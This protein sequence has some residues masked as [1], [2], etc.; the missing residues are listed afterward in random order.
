[1]AHPHPTVADM[2]DKRQAR[3]KI[4]IH[5]FYRLCIWLPIV[6]PAVLIVAARL[7]TLRLARGPVI[8]ELL[9]YSLLYG[10]IPY[11][12]VATVATGWVGTQTEERIRHVMYRAPLLMVAVFAPF[13]LFTGLA[14]GAL[15]PFVAVAV[16]GSIVIL[17]IGYGYVGLTMLLR[18]LFA[19]AIR[20]SAGA[21]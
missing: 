1:M 17:L 12:V 10:G 11:A 21:A 19:P 2:T 18:H 4:S 6:V 13:N 5:T 15:E 20:L 14:V 9:A 16:L 3:T 7:L 8:F